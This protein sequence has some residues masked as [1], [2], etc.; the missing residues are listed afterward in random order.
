MFTPT[1]KAETGHDEALS[2]DDAIALVGRDRY[3][4]LRD[5]SLRL[6][7]HGVAH[8]ATCGV[9][10]ADTKFEFGERDG[11]LMLIDECM[12]PD[13][14]RY[15]PAEKYRVGSSPP[16]FDKQFVRDFMDATGWDRVPPAPHLSP[17]AI[18]STR[19]RYIEAYETI[20]GLAFDDW[21]APE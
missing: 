14:S 19:A 8:A 16:S 13:S 2:Q 17:D 7:E 1:T 10:L 4:Q 12:T 9:V 21:F 6:Y 5:V 15:W 18:N 3:D 11:S 20:T